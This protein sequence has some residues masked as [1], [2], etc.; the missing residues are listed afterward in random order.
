ML[1][2]GAAPAVEGDIMVPGILIP[3]ALSSSFWGQS[4]LHREF[5]FELELESCSLKVYE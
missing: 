1:D 2:A 4:L 5:E 3:D